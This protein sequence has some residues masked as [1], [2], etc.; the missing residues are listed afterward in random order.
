MMKGSM[1][2]FPIVWN[3]LIEDRVQRGQTNNIN[4]VFG[5]SLKLTSNNQRGAISRY[6]HGDLA[7]SEYLEGLMLDLAKEETRDT[8]VQHINALQIKKSAT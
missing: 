1:L 6:L 3:G 8:L 7:I 4:I 5:S 2:T